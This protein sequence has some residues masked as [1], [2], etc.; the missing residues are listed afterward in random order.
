MRD[1]MVSS[2]SSLPILLK[3]SLIRDMKM[4][5]RLG[6]LLKESLRQDPATFRS[7]ITA[8]WPQGNTPNALFQFRFLE[9]SH[10]W[11]F[12]VIVESTEHTRQQVVHFHI[13]EGHLLV[14]RQPIGKLPSEYTTHATLTVLFGNQNLLSYPSNLPGMAYTL[15]VVPYGH[16][17]HLGFRNGYL[18]IRALYNNTILELIPYDI[19]LSPYSFDLPATLTDNC[20]HWLDISTGKI[21]IRQRPHIWKNKDTNWTLDFQKGQ[22]VRYSRVHIHQFNHQS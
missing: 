17:I 9:G 22:A 5:Y 10:Q 3:F 7:S 2:V 15:K 11:W 14:D 21:N 13:L 19:F 4:S 6:Y 20:V 16:Q 8:L 18:I 1:N 12:E